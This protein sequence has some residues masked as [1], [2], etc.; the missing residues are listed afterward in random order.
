MSS[1]L[2]LTLHSEEVYTELRS[3]L[4]DRINDK[5]P[6]IRVQAVIS[7]SKLCGTED[8]LDLAE[9]EQTVSEVL[10]ETLSHDPAAYVT[11][12][13]WSSLANFFTAKYAVPSC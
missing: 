6:A 11:I 7:L 3:S 9:G 12:N 8:P 1:N 2:F 10:M 5:E 13:S 4:L